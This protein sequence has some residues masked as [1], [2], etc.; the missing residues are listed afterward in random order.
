MWLIVITVL[1]VVVALIGIGNI[2]MGWYAVSYT[3]GFF[4]KHLIFGS[5]LGVAAV[6]GC[7]LLLKPI[8]DVAP[9]KAPVTAEQV[10]EEKQEITSEIYKNYKTSGQVD[11][12]IQ[13]KVE[14]FNK[15]LLR[16][17]ELNNSKIYSCLIQDDID[18]EEAKIDIEEVLQT[19]IEEDKEIK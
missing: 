9:I 7:I 15:R 6:V 19:L 2:L 17:E 18:F 16:Y 8:G 12:F 1:L 13:S 3:C 11:P 5:I 4:N 10:L 14:S